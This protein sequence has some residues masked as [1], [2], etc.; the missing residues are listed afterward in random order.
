M[1]DY[2]LFALIIFILIVDNP[3]KNIEVFEKIY[4]LLKYLLV[5]LGII[6]LIGLWGG[7]SELDK[8]FVSS[9]L[10]IGLSYIYTLT[11]EHT[12]IEDKVARKV[13]KVISW[14]ILWCVLGVHL[15]VVYIAA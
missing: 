12:G 9:V 4:K 11:T 8:G 6:H 5:F 13:F 7:F 10:L 1:V 3:F 2:L 15:Y 14:L